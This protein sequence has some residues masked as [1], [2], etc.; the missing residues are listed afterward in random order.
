MLLLLLPLPCPCP[1]FI[2]QGVVRQ[3][4]LEFPLS[5]Q[6]KSSE[7]ATG[8]SIPFVHASIFPRRPAFGT[9]P[10]KKRKLVNWVCTAVLLLVLFA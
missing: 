9:L 5:A 8:L 6:K 1:N 7:R 2:A 10:C 4:I 3:R